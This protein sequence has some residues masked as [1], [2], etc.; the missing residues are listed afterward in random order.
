MYITDNMSC[1][2]RLAETGPKIASKCT[3]IYRSANEQILKTRLP[4]K[5]ENSILDIV[6]LSRIQILLRF[7]FTTTFGSGWRFSD[8]FSDDQIGQ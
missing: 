6:Y 3:D 5:E 7:T 2:I 4:T 1:V 8:I